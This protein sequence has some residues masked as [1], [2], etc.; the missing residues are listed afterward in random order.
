MNAVHYSFVRLQISP[1]R[2]IVMCKIEKNSRSKLRFG[3]LICTIT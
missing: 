1:P 3:R 2:F